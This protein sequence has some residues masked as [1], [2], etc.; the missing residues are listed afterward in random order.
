MAKVEQNKSNH[1]NSFV[2]F[3]LCHVF[4]HPLAKASHMAELRGTRW[5][6]LQIQ[7]AKGFIVRSEE[8]EPLMQYMTL[9]RIA[10]Q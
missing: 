6:E 8:L 4:W 10:M 5:E 3:F 7:V 1:T 9:E 2:G